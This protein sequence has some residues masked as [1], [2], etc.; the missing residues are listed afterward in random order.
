MTMTAE[1]LCQWELAGVSADVAGPWDRQVLLAVLPSAAG[2]FGYG[3]GR[4]SGAHVNCLMFVPSSCQGNHGTV[5]TPGRHC[6]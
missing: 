6:C 4:E 3:S 2:H 1:W 5:Q